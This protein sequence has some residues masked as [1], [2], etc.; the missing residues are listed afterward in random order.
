MIEVTEAAKRRGSFSLERI[1]IQLPEG[2]I[3]GLVGANGAG[4][5]TLIQILLGLLQP[6]VGS[7]RIDGLDYRREER[8]IREEIGYVL[9]EELFQPGMSVWANADYYGGYYKRY[10]KALCRKYLEE[11]EVDGR[12]KYKVLSK[13]EK[14]KFQFAFALA[15]YP[16]YLIMDEPAGNFDPDFAKNFYGLLTE[17]VS[18]GAHSVL[19]STHQTEGLER[20]ADYV[21][22]LQK[23][24]LV[25]SEDIES[26]RKR[27]KIISGEK[28]KIKLLPEERVIFMEENAYGAKALAVNSRI[29]PFDAELLV[30]NPS[31]EEL[32]Y[33]ITKGGKC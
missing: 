9:Q 6:D 1:N 10:D 25:F 7:V 13:G 24:K 11:F 22:F 33:F 5:T 12:R 23:G 20:I 8:S 31:I 27:Y 16:K 21:T 3:M 32:M 29:H 30:E 19:L 14:L 18:D 28:Y 4:K 2:C 17:F 15:H 26:L